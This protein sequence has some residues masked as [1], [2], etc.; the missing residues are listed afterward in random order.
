MIYV[1]APKYY[2]YT[3]LRYKWWSHLWSDTSLEEL[4]AFAERLGLKREW[5]QCKVGPQATEE[6]KFRRAHYDVVPTK[7][8]KA[9][10]FGAV[11]MEIREFWEKRNG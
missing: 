5:F 10:S 9:L 1:D 2:G 8:K 3:P 7:R 6:Q 11:P 4:H